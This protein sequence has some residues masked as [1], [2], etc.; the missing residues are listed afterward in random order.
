MGR[1]LLV[2]Q[3]N[4]LPFVSI[5]APAWGAT[6][7]LINNAGDTEVSI[8]AP[9]WGATNAPNLFSSCRTVSIHAPAWGATQQRS[10][11]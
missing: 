6:D 10:M 5:H 1:D 9:A 7:E 8:H 11:Q 2:I 4:A 3:L